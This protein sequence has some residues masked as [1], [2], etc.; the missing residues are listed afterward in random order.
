MEKRVEV[1]LGEGECCMNWCGRYVRQVGRAWQ[2]GGWLRFKKRG[3]FYLR[4]K[5]R[6]G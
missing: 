2:S 4:K 5:N 1:L 3:V 6:C